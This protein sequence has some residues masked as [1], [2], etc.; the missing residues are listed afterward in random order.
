MATAYDIQINFWDLH[1]QDDLHF[2]LSPPESMQVLSTG[3][4]RDS[5]SVGDTV[6]I[7][8][9]TVHGGGHNLALHWTRDDGQS[10]TP[11]DPDSLGLPD[12][13]S[14]PADSAT[15]SWVV[16]RPSDPQPCLLRVTAGGIGTR[17]RPLAIALPPSPSVGGGG[18]EPPNPDENLPIIRGHNLP[19]GTVQFTRSRAPSDWTVRIFD[20]RGRAVRVE[21]LPPGQLAWTWRGDGPSGAVVGPGVYFVEIRDRGTG[22]AAREGTTAR[23]RVVLLPR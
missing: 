23:L 13:V 12:S 19:D 20:V 6:S 15:V 21:H 9:A 22:G 3:F 16:N 10:L 11:V 7:Q 5:A 18:D 4:D 14:L 2:S 17:V 1:W 8:L